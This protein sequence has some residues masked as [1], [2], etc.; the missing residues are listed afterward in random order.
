MGIRS[1]AA[2]LLLP[3]VLQAKHRN[4][5]P[6]AGAKDEVATF[7]A[8]QDKL[9]YLSKAEVKQ[10]REAYKF[11]DGAHLGQF[12]ASGE[13]YITHPLAVATIGRDAQ[14]LEQ[15]RLLAAAD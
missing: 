15:A 5:A 10:I 6:A 8:L 13:P 12:R 2:E 3:A 4:T 7:A 11:A 1:F 14:A 9:G